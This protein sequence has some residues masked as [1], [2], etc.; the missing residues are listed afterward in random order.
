MAKGYWII[1][2]NAHSAGCEAI[3][4]AVV[5]A[6]RECGARIVVMGEPPASHNERERELHS[7]IEFSSYK[8]AVD[9]YVVS[10]LKSCANVANE[11]V[12]IIERANLG[13][14]GASEHYNMALRYG[15]AV[16]LAV[17]LDALADSTKKVLL[18]L[19]TTQVHGIPGI[20]LVI[21]VP[22]VFVGL[23]YGALWLFD[24][25]FDDNQRRALIVASL[26]ISG[27]WNPFQRGQD[28]GAQQVSRQAPH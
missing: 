12:A 23:V 2:V 3:G 6:R 1:R 11:E 19:P 27:L 28:P 8:K 14:L 5:R 13:P 22:L 20:F 9:C 18:S 4:E 7:V 17:L 21:L 26:I 15:F 16:F 10:G 25:F 24:Q